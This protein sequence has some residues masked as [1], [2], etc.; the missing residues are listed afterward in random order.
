MF[1]SFDTETHAI[2]NARMVQIGAVMADKSFTEVSSLALLIQPDGWVM[3]EGAT[4]VNGITQEHAMRYGVPAKAAL[5][6]FLEM[7]KLCRCL[8]VYNHTFDAGVIRREIAALGS[9]DKG[10]DRPGL[11]IVD[12]IRLGAALQQDGRY[13]KLTVLH[14][15]LLGWEFPQAHDGLEDARATLRCARVL[16]ERK[17]WE[18]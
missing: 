6:T 9:D 12:V 16:L 14:Q 11:R 10:I 2:A 17:V 13:V 4:A 3:G 5:I 18:L 8:I 7:V 15:Q 1:L